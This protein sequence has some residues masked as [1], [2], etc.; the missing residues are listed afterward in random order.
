MSTNRAVRG[1]EGSG[2]AERMNVQDPEDEDWDEGLG[3]EDTAHL[4]VAYSSVE[5]STHV[6]CIG[7]WLHI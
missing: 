5:H 7:E 2:D 1:M 3:K 4:K 6:H